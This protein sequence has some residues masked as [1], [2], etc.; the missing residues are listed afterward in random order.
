MHPDVPVPVRT[1]ASRVRVL[2][3]VESIFSERDNVRLHAKGLT[4]LGFEV[5]VLDLTTLFHPQAAAA[6]DGE[7]ARDQQVVVCR[8]L[9]EAIRTVRRFKPDFVWSF[10]GADRSRYLARV[11]LRALFKMSGGLIEYRARGGPFVTGDTTTASLPVKFLK[12]LAGL[13]IYA[14]WKILTADYSFVTGRADLELA[15]G[16]PIVVHSLDYDRYLEAREDSTPPPAEPYLLFLDED[17]AFHID[18]VYSG[19]DAPV[20]ADKYYAEVN[21]ML[22][23]IGNALGLRPVI[24]LHTR[25]DV[26]KARQ[27][28]RPA[29][30]ADATAVAVKGAALVVTHDSTAVQLAVLM[31][32]PVLLIE[33]SEI[34]LSTLYHDNVGRM[35]AALRCAILGPEDFPFGGTLPAI[36]T[37]A[38]RDYIS[39]YI[40]MPQSPDLAGCVILARTL[41]SL[42]QGRAA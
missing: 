14:P 34:V 10:S 19:V 20:S 7:R 35:G 21:V 15:S 24:Q 16:V 2:Y 3:V 28:Y 26:S 42:H 17:Y 22:E 8:S 27:Y 25:A 5:L 33:T 41:L 37:Q 29:I 11:V 31:N 40:K 30:S 1:S 36:D 4:S 39:E 32:K 13:V 12:R 6:F 9:G 38:Y 23:S 18:Y